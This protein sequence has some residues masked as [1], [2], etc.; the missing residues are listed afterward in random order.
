MATK[1]PAPE[2]VL[3][4]VQCKCTKTRCTTMQYSYKNAGLHCT[5]LCMCCEQDDD[6]CDNADQ[7]RILEEDVE[8]ENEGY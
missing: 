6:E 5:D 7:G 8:E 1:S 4:L 3:H 2:A